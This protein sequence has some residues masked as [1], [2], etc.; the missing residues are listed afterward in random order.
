MKI[1]F[2]RPL[3]LRLVGEVIRSVG[4]ENESYFHRRFK[5]RFH[6]SPLAMRKR[7]ISEGRR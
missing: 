6:T 2:L 5:E 3:G 7:G 1:V 4:Y